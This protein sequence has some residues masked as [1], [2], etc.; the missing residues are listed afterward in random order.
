MSEPHTLFADRIEKSLTNPVLQAALD[1]NAERRVAG[2]NLR[3]A[4]LPAGEA[5]RDRGRAIRI[6][7]LSKL[8]QYLEQFTANVTQNGGRVH[9]AAT[10]A[11]AR[12]II[13]RID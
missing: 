7:T 10:A 4:E 13:L 9:W 2:R 8:D 1:R 11:E 6:E 3:F 12:Q 5:V